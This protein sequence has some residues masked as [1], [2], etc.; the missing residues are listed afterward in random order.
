[1]KGPVSI[2][3]ASERS[4]PTQ[5]R[6]VVIGDSDFI[7]NAQLDNAGNRDLLQGAVYWLM[8]QEQL[9]GISPKPIQAL[10][11]NLT[12]GQLKSLLFLSL[13]AMPLLCVVAG[14]GTWWLRR[15]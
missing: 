4:A 15:T 11:L 2:A 12:G 9:I 3:V 7:A 13:L 6:L 1:M 5:T 8:N 10:K 14:A